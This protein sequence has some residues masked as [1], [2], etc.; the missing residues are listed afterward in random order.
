L[1]YCFRKSSRSR[2]LIYDIDTVEVLGDRDLNEV[3]EKCKAEAIS[4]AV[5]AGAKPNTVKVVEVEN[6]PVQVCFI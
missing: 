3:L 1:I 2:D 6:L 4:R 5:Q